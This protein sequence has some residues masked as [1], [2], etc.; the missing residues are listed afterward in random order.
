VIFRNAKPDTTE[1]KTN[2]KKYLTDLKKR[3]K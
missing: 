1:K 3:R 2:E